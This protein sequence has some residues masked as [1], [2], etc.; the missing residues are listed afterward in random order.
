MANSRIYSLE[1]FMQMN[2][3]QGHFGSALGCFTADRETLSSITLPGTIPSFYISPVFIIYDVEGRKLL[4][5]C[6]CG[7]IWLCIAGVCCRAACAICSAVVHNCA[8][9]IFSDIRRATIFARFSLTCS[10]KNC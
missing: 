4:G 2:G 6:R 10:Q 1:E 7:A 9:F 8:D 5:F 3:I